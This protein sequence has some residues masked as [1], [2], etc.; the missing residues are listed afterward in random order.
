MFFWNLTGV[1]LNLNMSEWTVVITVVIYSVQNSLHDMPLRG[2]NWK[3][4]TFTFWL[5]DA[6]TSFT[7]NNCT[8]CSASALALNLVEAFSLTLPR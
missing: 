8:F 1:V 4:L 2:I 7:F 3:I 5:R 6:P